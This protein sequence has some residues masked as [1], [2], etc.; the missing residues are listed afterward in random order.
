MSVRDR[1]FLPPEDDAAFR[2]IVAQLR[3]EQ[4]P[5]L[6]MPDGTRIGLPDEVAMVLR[7]VVTAMAEGKAVTV[8]PH[9]TTLTTQQAADLLGVSRPTL[10]KLLED[11][12]IPYSQPGRHRRLRLSDVLDYRERIRHDRD[13]NLDE[14]ADLSDEAGL[15]EDDV[16]RTRLQR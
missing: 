7:D 2:R 13:R 6:V 5:E 15:Y 11:E 1:T 14:L 4:H 8:A 3:E 16:T 9:H 10:I 12:Q